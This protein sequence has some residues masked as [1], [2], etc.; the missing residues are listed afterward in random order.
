MWRDLKYLLAY[1]LPLSALLAVHWGGGWSYATVVYAFGVLPVADQYWPRDLRNPSAESEAGRAANRLFD[2]LLYLNVPLLYLV[3]GYAFYRTGQGAYAGY[4]LVGLVLSLGVLGG[5]SGI[6]VAHELNHRTRP[7]ERLLAKLLLW[8]TLYLH[9]TVEHNL[10]HHR[11]VATPLDPAT[12]RYGESVYHFWGRSVLG[13]W[14]SAWA[15]ERKRVGA[16]AWWRNR[17][18]HFQLA[19]LGYLLLVGGLFGPLATLVALGAGIVAFL[20]LETV[21]YIEHYGLLRRRTPGGRYEPVQPHHSWNSDH[22]LGRIVLY[23][24]TRH[25][26]HHFRAARKYQILRRFAESPQLPAGYPASM[27]LALVPPLWFGVMNERVAPY[28]TA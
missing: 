28:R 14:R 7:H 26:D 6:N 1:S 25:S 11:H 23:E 16:H 9:F 15:L 3:F 17:I 5:A 19:Q 20:N 24:L 27:L 4:E 22:E 12:A 18:L 8:P 10:G 13:G 2:L 21:N